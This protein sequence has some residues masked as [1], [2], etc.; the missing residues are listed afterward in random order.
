MAQVPVTDRTD[1]ENRRFNS[2]TIPGLAIMQRDVSA[3]FWIDVPKGCGPKTANV[4]LEEKGIALSLVVAL[5]SKG[6]ITV[7][8]DCFGF[9]KTVTH[10]ENTIN[11]DAVWP[12]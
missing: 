7:V 12:V 10:N 9:Q 2:L 5:G 6:E 8:T 1:I 11:G 3:V 4:I